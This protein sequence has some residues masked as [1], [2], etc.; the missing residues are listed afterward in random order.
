MNGE[1]RVHSPGPS[2]S[3]HVSVGPDLMSKLSE[4]S[5]FQVRMKDHFVYIFKISSSALCSVTVHGHVHV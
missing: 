1:R 2:S 5:K 4:C 3:L